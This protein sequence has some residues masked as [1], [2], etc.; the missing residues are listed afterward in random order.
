MKNENNFEEITVE[1]RKIERMLKSLEKLDGS[2]RVKLSYVLIALFPT[3]W[4][5]IQSTLK[6]AYTKGYLQGYLQ[7]KQES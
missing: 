5:N 4:N 2:A 6:D 1:K 3:V 7:G